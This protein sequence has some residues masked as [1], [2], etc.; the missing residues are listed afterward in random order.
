MLETLSSNST[1]ITLSEALLVVPC[2]T[3]SFTLVNE[4]KCQVSEIK[5][6]WAELP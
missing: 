1:Q 3:Y 4:L 2:S 5:S 6:D